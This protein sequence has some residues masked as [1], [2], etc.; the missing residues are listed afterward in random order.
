MDPARA[1]IDLA[2]KIANAVST[3][4]AQPWEILT[5]RNPDGGRT[6]EAADIARLQQIRS[7]Y[8]TLSM[9]GNVFCFREAFDYPGFSINEYCRDLHPNPVGESINLK[10]QAWSESHGIW[11][12]GISEHCHDIAAFLH[13]EAGEDRFIAVAKC[14]SVDWYLNDSI[15]REWA[16][17]MSPAGQANAMALREHIVEISRAMKVAPDAPL[18]DKACVEMLLEMQALSGHPTWFSRF[19]EMWIGHVQRSCGNINAEN[20]GQV[21]DVFTYLQNSPHQSGLYYTLAHFEFSR[22]E[23]LDWSTLTEYCLA[24]DVRNLCWLCALIGGLSNDL[25]SFEKEFVTH[26][27]QSNFVVVLMLN[28]PA[29][30]LGEVVE[31]IMMILRDLM[32]HFVTLSG[33]LKN[34]CAGR[35]GTPAFRATGI[36]VQAVEWGIMTTWVWQTRSQRYQHARSIFRETQQG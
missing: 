8:A 21:P 26:Q 15:G 14:L 34:R 1:S 29:L 31:A 7:E 32:E 17:T 35:H 10:I 30:T 24:S 4:S 22:D 20:L 16:P 11:I 12:P 19:L 23:Y 28:Y 5:E 25:I 18:I 27:S 9:R 3:V 2:T 6:F 13:P 36:F 33:A